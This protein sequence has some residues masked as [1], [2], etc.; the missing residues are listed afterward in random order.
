M[1]KFLGAGEFGVYVPFEPLGLHEG[2]FESILRRNSSLRRNSGVE[3]AGVLF[4]AGPFTWLCYVCLQADRP[5]LSCDGESA[6]LET[7]RL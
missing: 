3:G 1:Y 4:D 2:E 6:G 7:K 5:L